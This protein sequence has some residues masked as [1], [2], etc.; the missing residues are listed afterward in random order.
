MED[1]PLAHDSKPLGLV[2]LTFWS[3]ILGLASIPAGV[4]LLA[5]AYGLWTLQVWTW[6][7][8]WWIYLVSIPLGLVFI[9]PI[10]PGQRM[11]GGNTVLQIIGIESMFASWL[12]CRART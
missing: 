2:V 7:V 4:L 6:T 12:I 5:S 11:S 8:A 3:A 9:F 1:A 10:L